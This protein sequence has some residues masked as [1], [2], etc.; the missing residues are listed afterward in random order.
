MLLAQSG[1][2]DALIQC[3]LSGVKRTSCA[4]S[5][6]SAC[7]P[8][9]TW[10]ANGV[11]LLYSAAVSVFGSVMRCERRSMRHRLVMS[12]KPTTCAEG[13][14]WSDYQDDDGIE[15]R[16][17][18]QTLVYAYSIVR[19]LKADYKSSHRPRHLLVKDCDNTIFRCLR[20][21]LEP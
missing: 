1:H 17:D 6:M 21:A 18:A 13:P 11:R 14:S 4:H 8:K 7:D 19:E 3:P 16:S 10:P 12:Q 20:V 2:P 15:L 9:R 5:E